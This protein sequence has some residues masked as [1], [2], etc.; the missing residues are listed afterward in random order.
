MLRL[1]ASV[2]PLHGGGQVV[3]RQVEK[4]E[5]SAAI[6]TLQ[7]HLERAASNIRTKAKKKIASAASSVA[8]A[9]SEFTPRSKRTRGDTKLLAMGK[10]LERKVSKKPGKR[11]NSPGSGTSRGRGRGTDG[12]RGSIVETEV[13][14]LNRLDAQAACLAAAEADKATTARSIK[15]KDIQQYL[16]TQEDKT[17][18]EAPGDPDQDPPDDSSSSEGD[19]D[20]GEKDK[21]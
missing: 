5:T 4:D 1:L 16:T 14:K 15:S 10:Q 12:R 17:G 13:N 6:G 19:E 2:T 8:S 21:A 7:I 3:L 9:A 11:A 20:L 18:H